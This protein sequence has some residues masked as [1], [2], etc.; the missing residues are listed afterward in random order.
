MLHV[1]TCSRAGSH[2]DSDWSH[3]VGGTTTSDPHSWPALM[4]PSQPRCARDIAITPQDSLQTVLASVG[5]TDH[6]E[7]FQVREVSN[8]ALR[9]CPNGPDTN[10]LNTI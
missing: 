7:L 10:A 5:L 6:M 9:F 4:K 1:Y 3:Q 8:R 2:E